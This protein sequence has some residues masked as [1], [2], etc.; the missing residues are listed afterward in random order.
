MKAMVI[1]ELMKKGSKEVSLLKSTVI[2][3]IHGKPK[4]YAR[5]AFKYLHYD[6]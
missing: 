1:A 3:N 4:S 5:S 2:M 6:N